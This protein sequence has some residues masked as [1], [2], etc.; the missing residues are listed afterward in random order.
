MRTTF[1]VTY[2]GRSGRP[3]VHMTAAG[4]RY[5]MVR[6]KGGGVKR[7]YE[8]SRYWATQPSDT[9]TLSL[10]GGRPMVKKRTTKRKS[11]KRSTKRKSTKKATR[12]GSR[13]KRA[14]VLV[15]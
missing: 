11:T 3:V 7:L 15:I 13:K 14:L 9:R 6:K 12:K 8:G 5:V 1:P 2:H 10:K 4:R